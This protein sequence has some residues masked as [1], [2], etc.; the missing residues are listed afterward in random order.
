LGDI[1]HPSG[2]KQEF[3][4]HFFW[5]LCIIPKQ[6][7]HQGP[8]ILFLQTASFNIILVANPKQLLKAAYI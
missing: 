7:N 3:K 4:E 6:Q 1:V 5:C 8:G 2:F